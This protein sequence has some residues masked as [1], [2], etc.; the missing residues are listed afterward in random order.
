MLSLEKSLVEHSGHTDIKFW[1]SSQQL[2]VHQQVYLF[3][4]CGQIPM[5]PAVISSHTQRCT[6]A[7]SCHRHK[8]ME[9][10]PSQKPMTT[11]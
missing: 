10:Q 9:I 8:V 3:W 5:T 2:C 1:L 7:K 4:N 6:V 11:T